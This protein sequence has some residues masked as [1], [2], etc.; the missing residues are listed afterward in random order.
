[1]EGFSNLETGQSATVDAPLAMALIAQVAAATI[2]N[3]WHALDLGWGRVYRFR[4][5]MP[6]LAAFWLFASIP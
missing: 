2:P 4:P 3:A 6:S 5:G 1:V